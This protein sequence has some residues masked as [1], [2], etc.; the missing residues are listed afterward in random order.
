MVA[1]FAAAAL[2]V[3]IPSFGDFLALIGGV[4]CT[5]AIYVLPHA[6]FLRSCGKQSGGTRCKRAVSIAILI[7]G[8]CTGLLTTAVAVFQMQQH[9]NADLDFVLLKYSEVS[10]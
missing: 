8:L 2:A 10:V 1:V 5:L 9:P 7:F 3:A 4:G 6:A